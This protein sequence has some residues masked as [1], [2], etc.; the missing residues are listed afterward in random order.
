M[1][2]ILESYFLE[3]S[4]ISKEKLSS[5][6]PY[7]KER[8]FDKHEYLLREGEVCKFNYF[9]VSGSLRL[10]S[11]NKD[12]IENTR[13]IAFQGKFATSFT[14]LIT[15]QPSIE[16]I[17]SLERSTVLSISRDDFF[18]LV[19]NEPAVNVIYRNILESAYITTQKRIYDLQG[20][21]SLQRLEW[22]LEQQP[23]VFE[24]VSNKVIASYLGVTPYTLSRLKTKL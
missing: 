11:V 23:D 18:F 8:K 12:G 1:H 6:S 20:A 2:A 17:Q 5:L 9:V 10:F 7:F 14:S 22:L 15:R 19:E 4:R 21:D 13:Y 24:R 3:R 16:Y